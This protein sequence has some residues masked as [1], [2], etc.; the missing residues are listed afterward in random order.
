MEKGTLDL[1]TL[2]TLCTLC[3]FYTKY[4]NNINKYKYG[5]KKNDLSLSGAHERGRNGTE[6]C[7]GGI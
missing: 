2:Y 7:E 3:S 6:I 4:A 1:C 5:R